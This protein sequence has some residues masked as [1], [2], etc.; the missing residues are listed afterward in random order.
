MN[1]KLLVVMLIVCMTASCAFEHAP[2]GYSKVW[3]DTF[4]G[5]SLDT[6]NWTIGCKD[7]ESGDLI[8]G[9]QGAYLLNTHY[10]G[11]ITAD[12]VW[13]SDGSLYLQNQKRNYTGTGPAGTY[14]YTTGWIM[15]MH[16]V[17]FNR[18]YLEMRAKYPSGV[19]VWP[20]FWLIAED[21]VWGPEWDIFEY[22][23]YRPDHG[24]DSMVTALA[25]DE[26][27]DIGWIANHIS[28]YNSTYDCHRWHVYGFEW[29][30]DY[31]KWYIDGLEVYHI[32]NTIGNSW[33]NEQMYIVLNN[34]VR[35]KSSDKNTTWPNYM[36]VDY[37]KLY[38]MTGNL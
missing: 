5:T 29:T 18:G 19:K 6:S 32:D 30:T 3:E 38:H 21:L 12:D 23:G 15:S 31:A 24:Y 17:H 16:K 36:I 20:A 2:E 9:A 13:V 14:E 28:G 4:D 37:I 11:Y 34:G 8:A 27:P 26:D 1:C 25:Y 7:P 22:F 10:A 33:P 35:T